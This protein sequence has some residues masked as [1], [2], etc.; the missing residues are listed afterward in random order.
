MTGLMLVVALIFAWE[1]RGVQLEALN[2]SKT[3]GVCV[4]NTTV[5]GL[6]GVALLFVLP[7]SG[8]NLRVILLAACI[9]LCATTTLLLVFGS[10]VY[11]LAKFGPAVVER[12]AAAQGSVGLA[13]ASRP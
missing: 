9:I 2:D 13:M 12:M 11:L 5:M 4:Y 8:Q 6:I 3:I 10:K 1:T 7:D